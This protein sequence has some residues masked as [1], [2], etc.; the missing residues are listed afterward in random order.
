MHN[1]QEVAWKSDVF[2]HLVGFVFYVNFNS[3]EVY[4]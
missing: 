1:A 4:S 3:N 2:R